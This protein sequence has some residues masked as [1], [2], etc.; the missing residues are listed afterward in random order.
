MMSYNDYQ[1]GLSNGDIGICFL[2]EQSGQRQVEVYF[3]VWKKWVLATRLPKSIETAFA[4]TIH[5]PSTRFTIFPYG[6]GAGSIC[7]KFIEQRVDLYCNYSSQ[8]SGQFIG[9]L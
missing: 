8:K 7:K 3:P 2:R 9:R 1:L 6:S 4:L 5:T